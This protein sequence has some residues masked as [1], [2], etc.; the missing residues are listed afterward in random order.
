MKTKDMLLALLVV[1]IWGVS[2]SVIKVGL[3]ELP[4]LLLSAL[5]FF[6]AAVPAV[7]FVP[8]PRATVKTV[9]AVG[10]LLGVIKFSLLFFALK[11]FASAGISSLILQIQVFFTIG[12]SAVFL[13]ERITQFQWM[14]MLISLIG[15]TFFLLAQHGSITTAGL[16]LIGLA[17]MAWALSNLVMKKNAGVNVFHLMVWACLIPPVPLLILS[18]F[19]ESA[20]P[21]NLV[22]DVS[23]G[24]W[25]SIL[26]LAY[27]A[28]L[29]AYALWGS[30]LGR[31]AAASVAPFALLIPIVGISASA[32]ILGER[33]YPAEMLAA[34][35]VLAGL[36]LCVLGERIHVGKKR[37]MRP[38]Y[39]SKNQ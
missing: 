11:G 13:R 27:A 39:S 14:G 28:T 29:G 30:L 26:F 17:A 34:V 35:V 18:V 4:P 19:F 1:T 10:V 21:W 22:A 23:F 33:L 37:H 25:L 6:I 32:A 7:F 2:F 38:A 36:V 12:L 15:F 3:H 31:Y 5:R 20:E 16:A 9:V 24:V 8:F